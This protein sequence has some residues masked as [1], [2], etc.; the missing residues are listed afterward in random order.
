VTAPAALLPE[1]LTDLGEAQRRFKG[2]PE[3]FRSPMAR[4]CGALSYFT[5][6]NFLNSG[7]E[8][9]AARYWRVAL[10]FVDH[11]GDRRAQSALYG[12]RAVFEESP[13]VSLALADD[14]VRI[15]GGVP[16][17]GAAWGYQARAAALASLGDHRE[18]VRAL[19]DL[20][21]TFARLPGSESDDDYA[22]S[23]YGERALRYT[24]CGVLAYAGRP[25][26]AAAS[27]DAGRALV[28]DGYWLPYADLE[29]RGAM[30]LVADGDPSEG[31]RHVV[32]TVEALPAEFRRSAVVRRG[33]VGVLGLVPA[34]AAGM[35]AVAEVRELLALPSGGNLSL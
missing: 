7:D 27:Q 5:A 8:R 16:C 25:A 3:R 1:L 24:E 2:A 6:I 9:S 15:A 21:D 29:L 19:G 14:A 10:R 11:C 32:R 23:A 18:S 31:A 30:C 4:V 34:G 26:D 17:E 35:P 20:T 33:A 13:S 28:P 22:G 12:L